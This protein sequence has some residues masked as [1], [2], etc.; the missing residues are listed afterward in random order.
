[1]KFTLF[2]EIDNSWLLGEKRLVG[3]MKSAMSLARLERANDS[4]GVRKRGHQ[5]D[6]GYYCTSEMNV[7]NVIG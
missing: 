1:M 5:G 3:R 4:F 6:L 2:S 7:I